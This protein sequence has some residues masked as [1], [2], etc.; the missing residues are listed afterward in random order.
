MR[1]TNVECRRTI[2]SDNRG[3]CTI[4]FYYYLDFYFPTIFE[5]LLERNKVAADKC[6]FYSIQCWFVYNLNDNV[7]TYGQVHS[8][9]FAGSFLLIFVGSVIISKAMKHFWKC[10]FTNRIHFWMEICKNWQSAKV[11]WARKQCLQSSTE[12]V[13]IWISMWKRKTVDRPYPAFRGWQD[14]VF[15]QTRAFALNSEVL[16]ITAKD[17]FAF[18]IFIVYSF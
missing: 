6:T 5:Q 2:P 12:I 15:H 1:N 16:K 17:V 14:I 11:R 7:V 8:L 18:Q 10:I 4:V 9:P 3:M 13:P